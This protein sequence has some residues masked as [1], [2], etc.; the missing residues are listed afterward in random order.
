MK[1]LEKWKIQPEKVGG[2]MLNNDDD[3]DDDGHDDDDEMIMRER[4][5]KYK[6]KAWNS[7]EYIRTMTIKFGT[8]NDESL[9]HSDS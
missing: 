5:V 6:A 9:K 4:I 2:E 3:D 7:R 1:G 8:I